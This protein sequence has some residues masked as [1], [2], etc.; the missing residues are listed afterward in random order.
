[1][2]K[3]DTLEATCFPDTTGRMALDVFLD[4]S[5]LEVFVDKHSAFAARIYPTLDS[6][7]SILVGAE[8]PGAILETITISRIKPTSQVDS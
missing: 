4:D 7:S 3:K 6:S 1:M 5:V 8:G 2:M